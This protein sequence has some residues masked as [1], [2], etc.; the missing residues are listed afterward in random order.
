MA[1]LAVAVFAVPAFTWAD[2]EVQSIEGWR[3]AKWGMSVADVLAAFKGEAEKLSKEEGWKDGVCLVKIPKLE[4]A[5]EPFDV[6]FVFEKD[7]QVLKQVVLLASETVSSPELTF[8]PLEQ[9]LTEKYGKPDFSNNE[10]SGS[11]KSVI[12][13]KRSWKKGKTRIE[14]RFFEIKE[15]I[16]RLTVTY[17]EIPEKGDKSL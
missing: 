16:K 10:I 15:V 4:L 13:K 9:K 17:E 7:K 5:G 2:Q 1:I 12:T 3:G 8:V 6:N 14:L 11:D